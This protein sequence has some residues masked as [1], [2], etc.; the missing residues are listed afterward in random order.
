MDEINT[1]NGTYFEMNL[2]R[3]GPEVIR[4]FAGFVR[5]QILVSRDSE[6]SSDL[7]VVRFP[8]ELR[9]SIT[10]MFKKKEREHL[11]LEQMAEDGFVPCEQKAKASQSSRETNELRP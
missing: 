9:D 1:A 2:G 8:A 7:F 10:E 6:E 3:H 5:R 11:M 4:G